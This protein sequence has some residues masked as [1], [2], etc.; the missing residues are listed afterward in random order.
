MTEQVREI[1]EHECLQKTG[2]LCR[3]GDAF[4]LAEWV[5]EQSFGRGYARDS[6]ELPQHGPESW[7]RAG[8]AGLTG[9]WLTQHCGRVGVLAAGSLNI[10]KPVVWA[11][12]SPYA[13]PELHNMI[14][15]VRG[16]MVFTGR[17]RNAGAELVSLQWESE[18]GMLGGAA[19][20]A[21]Q[22]IE[23]QARNE[24]EAAVRQI[25]AE[26]D[27]Y[28]SHKDEVLSRYEGRY[29]AILNGQVIDH[30]ADYGRLATRVYA[31]VGRRPV[32]LTRVARK[33]GVAVVHRGYLRRT[34]A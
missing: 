33:R 17:P 21:S 8:A 5:H 22:R 1:E 19:S 25:R 32:F 4:E 12:K 9:F 6:A 2:M 14:T 15:Q 3:Q 28:E 18:R 11:I 34:G 16:K 31:R 24:W 13:H 7:R 29:V 20:A 30:D 10:R 27:A 26:Q 23:E